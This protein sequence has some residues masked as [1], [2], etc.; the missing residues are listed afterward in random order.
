MTGTRRRLTGRIQ[1]GLPPDETF[2]LFT[3]RGE[4]DWAAGWEPRFPAPA[5][6][7][8]EPGT[9]FETDAHGQHTIWLVLDRPGGTRIC[10]ARVTPG[11]LA[12][13]VTIVVSAAGRHSEVD[14]TYE[15]IELNGATGHQ[16]RDFARAYPGYLQSWQDAIAAW[17][18]GQPQA[19][20]AHRAC[21]IGS[22][23]QCDP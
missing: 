7:D 23:A 20:P 5:P 9:V 21:P 1:V 8:T 4:Q 15:L 19:H 14:V 3:P 18:Q 10:Y 22:L 16:L 12:G 6:D 17:L 2:R 11:G 13:T